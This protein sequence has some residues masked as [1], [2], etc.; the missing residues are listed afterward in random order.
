MREKEFCESL[1]HFLNIRKSLILRQIWFD[2][3]W[4]MVA[5][6]RLAHWQH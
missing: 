6:L 2:R 5:G 4:T 1:F 3:I